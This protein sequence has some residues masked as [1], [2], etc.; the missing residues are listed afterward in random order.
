MLK[1][2]KSRIFNFNVALLSII[3]IPFLFGCG[4]KNVVADDVISSDNIIVLQFDFKTILENADCKYEK[5]GLE[6]SPA[7]EKLFGGTLLRNKSDLEKF[8][9][10]NGVDIESVLCGVGN[11][12]VVVTAPI[13]DKGG[14]CKWLE[15]CIDDDVK[16]VYADG[17]DIYALEDEACVFINDNSVCIVS[18]END[19]KVSIETLNSIKM[20]AKEHAL[21]DWQRDA[22]KK[23]NSCNMLI[24]INALNSR[25][26]KE[27]GYNMFDNY[28]LSMAYKSEELKDGYVIA[29][30]NL[31]GLKFTS[32]FV[33]V[34]SDG[35]EIKNKLS[36][37]KVNSNLIKYVNGNAQ[38]VLIMAVPDS[39][40]WDE[41]LKE[42]PKAV[43]GF[44]QSD[45][46]NISKYLDYVDG[47]VMF[48]FGVDF[49]KMA[50]GSTM[51]FSFTAAAEIEKGKGS[52][53]LKNIAEA[54]NEEKLEKRN[55]VAANDFPKVKSEDS[56]LVVALDAKTTIIFRVEDSV[57]TVSNESVSAGKCPFDEANFKGKNFAW[58]TTLSPAL[59]N[60]FGIK[61]P[62]A[63]NVII[64]SEDNKSVMNLEMSET[65][66]NLLAN[67]FSFI[68]GQIR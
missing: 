4:K 30:A 49:G 63:L 1:M 67:I 51:P 57:L 36:D 19:E 35:K 20:N 59:F 53:L 61:M 47:T 28:M 5:N 52:E 48:S 62:F 46:K 13:T 34:N 27:G 2:E 11:Q 25:A 18:S 24:N 7:V 15:S 33:I 58:T 16:P 38:S 14:F 55:N 45:I 40:N 23:G 17:Y 39:I 22:L 56:S 26:K 9:N 66:G 68:A 31:S 41:Y 50:M 29:N 8:V 64:Y 44:S 60:S 12:Y 54:I 42:M 32:D 37:V 6:L 43:S 3:L 21:S 65:D 10:I